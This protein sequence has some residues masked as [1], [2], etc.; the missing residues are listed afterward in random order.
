MF[1]FCR[2]NRFTAIFTTGTGTQTLQTLQTL[3][4]PTFTKATLVE[5][6]ADRHGSGLVREFNL[7]TMKIHWNE[8]INMCP[9]MRMYADNIWKWLC[10]KGEKNMLRISWKEKKHNLLYM[11]SMDSTDSVCTLRELPL[12]HDE[13]ICSLRFICF[14]VGRVSGG[15]VFL[16]RWLQRPKKWCYYWTAQGNC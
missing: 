14:H 7:L 13:I 4:G 11:D 1:L 6:V 3:P 15:S 9:C 5:N 16:G 8:K 10:V 2:T 12:W